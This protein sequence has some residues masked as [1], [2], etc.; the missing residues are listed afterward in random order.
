MLKLDIK[1]AYLIYIAFILLAQP[2]KILFELF[3][4]LSYQ[5]IS[6]IEML[7]PVFFVSLFKQKIQKVPNSYIYLAIGFTLYFMYYVILSFFLEDQYSNLIQILYSYFNNLHMV[8]LTCIFFMLKNENINLKIINKY[9]TIFIIY[10]TV[11]AILQNPFFSFFNSEILNNVGGNI[12]SR[13]A[14]YFRSNGGVGGTVIDFSVL[15]IIL[16][17]YFVGN[18]EKDFIT[19]FM[20]FLII[21]CLFLSF[22]RSSLLLF[23]FYY[24]FINY[25]KKSIVLIIFLTLIFTYFYLDIATVI[26]YYFEMIGHSDESRINGWSH[27]FTDFSSIGDYVF[28]VNMGANTGFYL[29][30]TGKVIGDGSLFSYYYDY[31]IFGLLFLYA[32]YCKVIISTDLSV[33]L[34][35]PI[36]ISIILLLIVNSGL[37]KNLVYFSFVLVLLCL[38][39]KCKNINGK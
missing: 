17:F 36:F 2:L 5:F 9:L 12:T 19:N 1:K 37:E 3:I 30:G 8:A 21:I 33:S 23:F 39:A 22:S 10:F 34:K 7:L 14:F 13:N 15:L 25:S 32:T 28:G 20:I 4:G 35:I 38:S 26:D 16:T 31:G 18:R 29:S 27:V 6:V 11:V 24:Q